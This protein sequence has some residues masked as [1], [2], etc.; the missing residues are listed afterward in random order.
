MSPWEHAR[1]GGEACGRCGARIA[2]GAPILARYIADGVV[3]K[4]RCEACAGAP[5]NQAELDAAPVR[6]PDPPR[7]DWDLT[8]RR[9]RPVERVR[10]P[11]PLVPLAD[12]AKNLPFDGRMAAA[13]PDRDNDAL[14]RLGPSELPPVTGREPGEDDQ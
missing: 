9:R 6:P 1:I 3:R 14:E 5:V 8:M 10:P 4:V 11:R 2:D 13:G 7:R 12:I